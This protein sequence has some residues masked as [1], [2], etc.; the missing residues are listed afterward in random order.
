MFSTRQVNLRLWPLAVCLALAAA[1][2]GKKLEP[3][4][5]PRATNATSSSAAASVPATEPLTNSPASSNSHQT[6]APALTSGET[7]AAGP[8]NPEAEEWFRQGV[9]IL[10]TNSVPDMF[11]AA[12]AFKKGAELGHA[13]SQQAL[14]SLYLNGDGVQKDTQE[15]IHLLELSAAQN[16]PEAQ[17]KLASVY[18]RGIGVETNLEKAAQYALKAAEQGHV[19]AQYNLATMYIVGK[20]VPQNMAEAARWMK[21]AAEAGHPTAQ[22]NLGVFYVNGKGV[23]ANMQEAARW[24]RAA[25]NQGQPTAQF[26]LGQALQDGKGAETD[27]IEAYQWFSLAADQGDRDAAEAMIELS[28]KMKPDQVAEA[29]KRAREFKPKRTLRPIQF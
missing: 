16:F 7:P 21:L 17:F 11:A 18:A 24:F 29:L 25:A 19:E 15:G 12:N 5:S 13:P 14:G 3:D 6:N 23:E 28:L 26:N 1:G 9:A 20:G 8:K 4:T 10:Q 27:F 2:C 22:S